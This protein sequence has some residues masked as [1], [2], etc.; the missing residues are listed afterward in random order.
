MHESYFRRVAAAATFSAARGTKADL[1]AGQHLFCG[2]N[3]FEPGQAQHV[4]TH[5][6]ADKFYLV[7]SGRARMQVGDEVAEAEAGTL[8]WCPADVPHGVLEALERTVMLVAIAPPPRR[9]G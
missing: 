9:G 7:L 4:H 8:V 3:C 5:A 1:A 6:G 2:L